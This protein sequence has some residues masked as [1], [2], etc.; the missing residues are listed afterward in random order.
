MKE[1]EEIIKA[2]EINELEHSW[3]SDNG[4]NNLASLVKD[5]A[6]EFAEKWE[7]HTY[8]CFIKCVEPESIEDFFDQF[9]KKRYEK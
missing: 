1:L 7:K 8:I 6:I 5:I 4:A 2:V 3:V 9:I